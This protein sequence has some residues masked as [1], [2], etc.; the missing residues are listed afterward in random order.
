MHLI[1][2]SKYGTYVP[3]CEEKKT[4]SRDSTIVTYYVNTHTNISRQE[5]YNFLEYRIFASR[6]TVSIFKSICFIID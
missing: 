3:L 6:G 4:Y 2:S 1:S 5:I